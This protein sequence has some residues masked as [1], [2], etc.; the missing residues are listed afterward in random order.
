MDVER[1][2]EIESEL[3][4]LSKKRKDLLAELMALRGSPATEKSYGHPL[5]SA[6]VI[7]IA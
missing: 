5:A 7:P 3:Q 6:N 1:I 4:I 2:R